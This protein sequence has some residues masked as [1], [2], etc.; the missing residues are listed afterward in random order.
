MGYHDEPHKYSRIGGR[1]AVASYALSRLRYLQNVSK[2][3]GVLMLRSNYIECEKVD[4]SA[5]WSDLQG[6]VSN[7][8]R[9][10]R[11]AQYLRGARDRSR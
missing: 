4:K 2:G 10:V 9:Q 5:R 8:S 6:K 3:S 1:I 7:R 11:G